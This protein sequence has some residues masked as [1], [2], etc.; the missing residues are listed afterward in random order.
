MFRCRVNCTFCRANPEYGNMRRHFFGGAQD[1][2]LVRLTL[3]KQKI[4]N[5]TYAGPFFKKTT[6][7]ALQCTACNATILWS[8][9]VSDSST[10]LQWRLTIPKITIKAIFLTVPLTS[11]IIV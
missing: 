10:V 4:I 7:N 9:S 11:F 2:I 1:L 8:K 3:F 5:K 6:Q